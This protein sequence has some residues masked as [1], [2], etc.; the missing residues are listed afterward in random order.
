MSKLLENPWYFDKLGLGK[1]KGLNNESES[2]GSSGSIFVFQSYNGD[3]F[4]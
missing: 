2:D 1:E 4:N 3:I